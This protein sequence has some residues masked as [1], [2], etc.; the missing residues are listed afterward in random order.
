[1]ETSALGRSC[2]GAQRGIDWR[3][4]LL[5]APTEGNLGKPQSRKYS[6][7]VGGFF[8]MVEECDDNESPYGAGTQTTTRT[9]PWFPGRIAY[10]ARLNGGK[11]D[12]SVAFPYG[13]RLADVRQPRSGHVHRKSA[14][15]HTSRLLRRNLYGALWAAAGRRIALA[16]LLLGAHTQPPTKKGAVIACE[17]YTYM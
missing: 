10:H 4:F 12:R 15:L 2:L 9:T 14:S 16:R 1:L 7:G 13:P 11:G 8:A 17:D 6:T 5:S 3:C